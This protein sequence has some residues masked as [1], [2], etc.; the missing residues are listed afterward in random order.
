[1]GRGKEEASVPLEVDVEAEA[2]GGVKDEGLFSLTSP[3]TPPPP[4]PSK[5]PNIAAGSITGALGCSWS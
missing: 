5:R 1:M 4:L 3:S 2:E